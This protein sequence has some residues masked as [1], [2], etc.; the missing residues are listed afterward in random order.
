ME[1][2]LILIAW[3]SV[4]FIYL[5]SLSTSGE[6][7]KLSAEATLIILLIFLPTTI[8]IYTIMGIEKIVKELIDG[9]G[10]M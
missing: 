3:F 2:L 10:Q 7:D 1:Y 8:T 9:K 5:L 4:G 6:Y